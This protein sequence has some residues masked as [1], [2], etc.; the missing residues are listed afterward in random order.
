MKSVSY[1]F[2]GE[3]FTDYYC[4]HHFNLVKGDVG[5]IVADAPSGAKCGE[6]EMAD[7]AYESDKRAEVRNEMFMLGVR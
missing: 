1:V 5:I 4:V 6:C 7:A 2:E 3:T